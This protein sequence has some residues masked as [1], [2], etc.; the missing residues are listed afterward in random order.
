MRAPEYD[1]FISYR[2]ADGAAEARLIAAALAQHGLRAFLDVTDL[3]RGHFDVTLLTKIGA[4]PNFLVVLTPGALDRCHEETDWL[5]QEIIQAIKSGRNIIPLMMPG[6]RFP[7]DLPPELRDLPRCQ[8]VEYSHSFFDATVSKILESAGASAARGGRFTN[9]RTLAAGLAAVALLGA[10]VVIKLGN[11]PAREQ[12]SNTVDSRPAPVA[13]KKDVAWDESL[14]SAPALRELLEGRPKAL[15]A[16]AKTGLFVKLMAVHDQ[17]LELLR[18]DDELTSAESYYLELTPATDGHLYVFQV[19]SLGKLTVLY[20]KLDGLPW[21]SGQNPVLAR[22]L[23]RVPS[24]RIGKNLQLDENI[25][26]EHVYCVLAGMRWPELED[27]MSGAEARGGRPVAVGAPFGF[28]QRGV[29]QFV[30]A[31]DPT[32]TG[33]LYQGDTGL[34][35]VGR[36]FRHAARRRDGT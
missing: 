29:A 18:D 15:P 33:A 8:G 32:G 20:P 31:S 16:E 35:V 22:S 12:P 34:L 23:V 36:W 10:A 24:E 27:A 7:A 2:R 9:K 11:R 1:I 4:T 14:A 6:F 5:R 30:P 25:G 13:P 21:S 3:K 26:I 28:T 19:D 17:R